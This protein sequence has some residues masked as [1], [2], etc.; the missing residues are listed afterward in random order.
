MARKTLAE[1]TFSSIYPLYLQKIERKGHNASELNTVI[2]WLTGYD[3]DAIAELARTDATLADFFAGAP[4]LNPNAKLI[5]GVICGV[6]VENITD[7]L[8]QQVRYLD[9]LVDEV[10]KGKQMA[11]ILR[12]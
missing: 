12:H 4:Q 9:K 1:M 2:T 10:A 11:N 3:N 5:T 7:P 6:R 8:T